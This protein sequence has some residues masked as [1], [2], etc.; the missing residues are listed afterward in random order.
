M[1]DASLKSYSTLRRTGLFAAAVSTLT[2]WFLYLFLGFDVIDGGTYDLLLSLKKRVLYQRPRV[3]LVQAS[4]REHPS[5]DEALIAARKLNAMGASLVAFI[6]LPTGGTVEAEQSLAAMQK[7]G[8]VVFSSPATFNPN[9][10]AYRSLSTSSRAAWLVSRPS[11]AAVPAISGGVYRHQR[12]MYA[13]AERLSP[14]LEHEVASAFNLGESGSEAFLI[15]Y[16]GASGSLPNVRLRDIIRDA[17]IPELVRDRVALVALSSESTTPTLTTPGSGNAKLSRLE[18]HG[19]AI[20]TLLKNNEIRLIGPFV[21]LGVLTLASAMTLAI[22]Q[23]IRLVVAARIVGLFSVLAV[24]LAFGVLCWHNLW[25]PIVPMLLVQAFTLA[26]VYDQRVEFLSSGVQR[27]AIDIDARVK[28]NPAPDTQSKDSPWTEIVMYLRQSLD[29][30]RMVIFDLAD[31]THRLQEVELHNCSF[32]DITERRRD[33]RR[34]PFSWATSEKRCI[35]LTA[36]RCTFLSATDVEEEQFLAPLIIGSRIIGF[37]VLAV[38][39]PYVESFPDFTKLLQDYSNQ[40]VDRLYQH[41]CA[42]A[43]TLHE[44]GWNPIGELPEQHAYN[45]LAESTT[46]L[47]RRLL[48]LDELFEKSEIASA[49]FSVSGELLTANACM[50][51]LIEQQGHVIGKLR[52]IDLLSKLTGS[53]DEQSRRRIRTVLRSKQ[54]TS[55]MVQLEGQHNPFMLRVRPLTNDHDETGDESVHR[56]RDWSTFEVHGVVCELIDQTPFMEISQRSDAIA[57]DLEHSVCNQLAAVEFATAMLVDSYSDEESREDFQQIIHEQVAEAATNI[58]TA[59]STLKEIANTT[60][61][62]L[63]LEPW[64]PLEKAVDR[65]AEPSQGITIEWDRD[66]LKS[67]VLSDFD[68]LVDTFE[69]ALKVIAAGVARPA[70]IEVTAEESIDRV[71]FTV[72][73]RLAE[74]KDLLLRQPIS[75]AD[76]AKPATVLHGC[77]RCTRLVAMCGGTLHGLA[78]QPGWNLSFS[79]PRF[80]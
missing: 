33:W 45:R 31:K 78:E 34:A 56:A 30:H 44:T 21:S 68:L 17:T 9:T 38:E 5:S 73:E 27:L 6:G 62:V 29:I 14:S 72:R 60:N 41:H 50:S 10:N 32:E 23:S 4:T 43:R 48:R 51:L 11:V 61:D 66:Q 7:K 76:M 79:L 57:D 65:I 2:I 54:P 3:V 12:R 59:Q 15:H 36:R 25:L 58:R 40:I 74:T 19:H 35:S 69:A 26:A 71:T 70:T 80:F 24:V 16:V 67:H 63:A 13:T 20:N 37:I 46:Q 18:F 22:C 55:V 52:L 42:R 64:H 28:N 75:D 53:S 47:E 8:V 49:V 1:I 77:D 39:K